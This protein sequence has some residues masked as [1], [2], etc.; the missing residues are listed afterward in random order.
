MGLSET[1]SLA[2]FCYPADTGPV[3][4]RASLG[5]PHSERVALGRG[6]FPIKFCVL[7]STF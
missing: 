6:R 3:E 2:I 5:M 1:E 7:R 4:D